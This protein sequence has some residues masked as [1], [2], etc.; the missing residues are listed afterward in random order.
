MVYLK[1]T[2]KETK[3]TS[4]SRGFQKIE[5]QR[6]QDSRHMKMVRLLVL[7]TGCLYPPKN[8]PDTHFC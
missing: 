8:I 3:A 2:V 5:G 4:R 7:R 1:K 6:F